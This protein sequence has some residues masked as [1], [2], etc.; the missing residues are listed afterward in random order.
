MRKASI[1]FLSVLTCILMLLSPAYATLYKMEPVSGEFVVYDDVNKMQW[2]SDLT[3]FAGMTYL[4]QL[5]RIDE[6]NVNTFAA[7]TGWHLATPA[8]I[9]GLFLQIVS[10]SDAQK[11]S[12]TEYLEGSTYWVGR[13][14]EPVS[15]SFHE[16]ATIEY[17]PNVP[18]FFEQAPT[19]A[20][21]P[22]DNQAEYSLCAWVV[23]DA[24]AVP[25]PTPILLLGTGLIGLTILRRKRRVE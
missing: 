16:A 2:V 24:S 14:E 1:V 7:Y 10:P 19:S 17:F 8:E 4:G 20:F 6:L 21:L 5:S 3:L 12:P 11:F 18:Q 25:T 15:P 23:T 13:Y 22:G 9:N